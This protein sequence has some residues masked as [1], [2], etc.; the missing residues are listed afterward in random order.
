MAA[1][2][3]QRWAL[4]LSAYEYSI[5]YKEGRLNAYCEALSRLPLPIKTE[6]DEPC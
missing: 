1:A 3:I 6:A 2:R 5:V 4:T